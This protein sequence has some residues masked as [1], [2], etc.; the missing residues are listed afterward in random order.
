MAGDAAAISGHLSGTIREAKIFRR[1][2]YLIGNTGSFRLGQMLK[3]DIDL[4]EPAETDDTMGFMVCQFVEA[5]RQ[6]MVAL[7]I[8]PRRDNVDKGGNFLVAIRD[9][10]FHI[11]EDFQVNERHEDYDAA[12]SGMEV[13]L[14]SLYSTGALPAKERLNQALAAADHFGSHVR[15]PYTMQ[16]MPIT[17][18]GS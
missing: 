10:I 6:R 5:V 8:S 17:A 7:S 4:P 2:A 14:G 1:G 16:D 11:Y 3:Y 15:P 9:R 18:S 12:G 13:A